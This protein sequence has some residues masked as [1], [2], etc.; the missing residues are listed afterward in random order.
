MIH[1][2]RSVVV[3]SSKSVY[4]K[5]HSWCNHRKQNWLSPPVSSAPC[6]PVNLARFKCTT[7]PLIAYAATVRLNLRSQC[8]SWKLVTSTPSSLQKQALQ[9]CCF[10]RRQLQ[11]KQPPAVRWS[12]CI[13][14]VR[15]QFK[16]NEG[17]YSEQRKNPLRIERRTRLHSNKRGQILGS[18]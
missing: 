1:C 8:Q 3:W 16:A 6:Q 17:I 2:R 15:V 5:K 12:T 7:T 4:L 11:P 10:S 13:P 14:T 18:G 9:A